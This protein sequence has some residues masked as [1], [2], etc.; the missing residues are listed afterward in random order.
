MNTPN[1][2]MPPGGASP[3][4]QLADIHLPPAVPSFPWAPGWWA[5]LILAIGLIA[6]GI[7]LWRRYRQRS[8]YRRAAQLELTRIQAIDDDAE[9]ARQLNQLLRRVAIHCQSASSS[10]PTIAGLSGEQ[11]QDFLLNSCGAKPAFT[12]TTLDALVA[13]AYQSQC[14]ALDRQQLLGQAR[15]WIRR[16]RSQYV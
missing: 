13:A 15:L 16:H 7:W 11:W 6:T 3:L 4:D 10:A 8:A 5:L 1:P 12:N 9:F 14:P 2:T